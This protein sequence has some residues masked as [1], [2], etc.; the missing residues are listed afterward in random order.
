MQTLIQPLFILVLAVLVYFG[1]QTISAA[2][3]R[4]VLRAIVYGV[5]AILA[6]IYVVLTLF[7]LH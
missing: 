4:N 7:G 6:L 5:V 1:D 3:A 2:I